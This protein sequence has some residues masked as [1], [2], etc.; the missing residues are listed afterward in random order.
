MQT[1]FGKAVLAGLGGTLAMTVIMLMAPLMGMPQMPVGAM[2]ANFM[3]IP[4]ALGWIAHFMIGAALAVIYGSTF[5]SRLPGSG[6]VRGLVY[7]LLPWLASQLMV[8]PMMGAGFFASNTPAPLLMVMGSLAGH[9]VYGAVVGGMYG[10][11]AP[12]LQH[13]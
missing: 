3:G 9:M 13:A 11:P 5:A 4:P 10:A 6:T 2:L 12:H 8:N 1:N 7:G